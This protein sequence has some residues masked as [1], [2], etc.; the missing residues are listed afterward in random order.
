MQV[1]VI[2]I[3]AEGAFEGT[4]QRAGLIGWQVAVTTLAARSHV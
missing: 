3:G 1:T 2:A 4:D